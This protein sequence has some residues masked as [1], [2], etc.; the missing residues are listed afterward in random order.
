MSQLAINAGLWEKSCKYW[1]LNAYMCEVLGFESS[2]PTM[3]KEIGKSVLLRAA[4]LTKIG[5]HSKALGLYYQ[6]FN[7]F[8]VALSHHSNSNLWVP[9]RGRVMKDIDLLLVALISIMEILAFLGQASAAW[10]TLQLIA[11]ISSE[12]HK[13]AQ[14]FSRFIM[15]ML[16]FYN[17]HLFSKLNEKHEMERLIT[18]MYQNRFEP[19]VWRAIEDPIAVSLAANPADLWEPKKSNGTKDAFYNICNLQTSGRTEEVNLVCDRLSQWEADKGIERETQKSV[20]KYQDYIEHEIMEIELNEGDERGT[21]IDKTIDIHNQDLLNGRSRSSSRSSQVSARVASKFASKIQ[22]RKGRSHKPYQQVELES[23]LKLNETNLHPSEDR[24]KSLVPLLNLTGD[25]PLSSFAKAD[26]EPVSSNTKK[27]T[28]RLKGFLRQSANSISSKVNTKID[29]SRAATHRDT[30]S[31]LKSETSVVSGP[32]TYRDLSFLHH[33]R[34]Q[35]GHTRSEL[36]LREGSADKPQNSVLVEPR[37]YDHE[38][39]KPKP[40]FDPS[41]EGFVARLVRDKVGDHKHTGRAA[42]KHLSK[43]NVENISLADIRHNRVLTGERAIIRSH[44]MLITPVEEDIRVD[45][46]EC[47]LAGMELSY[48]AS[49][50]IKGEDSPRLQGKKVQFEEQ[51][52]ESPRTISAERKI[53][54]RMS[55]HFRKLWPGIMRAS[56][57]VGTSHRL[58]AIMA[59]HP[60]TFKIKKALQYRKEM[61]RNPKLYEHEIRVRGDL[62]NRVRSKSEAQLTAEANSRII[63]NMDQ[64]DLRKKRLSKELKVMIN[65]SRQSVDSASSAR[66]LP[67]FTERCTDLAS[68]LLNQRYTRRR[69]EVERKTQLKQALLQRQDSDESSDT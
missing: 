40:L 51:S 16:M 19:K 41:L 17:T 31:Y 49:K 26:P 64:L 50:Y 69:E 67:L 35:S 65:T 46:K 24:R 6:A 7:M 66:K 56:S 14:E 39:F 53:K 28:F 22:S 1:K 68:S 54:P 18:T 5:E 59:A 10:E 30:H 13:P 27:Q 32:K 11:H 45:F 33:Q 37:N 48:E 61:I 3:V 62:F 44:R 47:S 2:N 8:L 25:K 9:S 43:L 4:T 21:K 63:E 34:A 52:A 60:E 58:L 12:V 55:S 57:N 42:H 23:L 15:Q 29:E 36:I 38:D 20:H